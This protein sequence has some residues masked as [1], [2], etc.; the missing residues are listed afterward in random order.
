MQN[1]EVFHDGKEQEDEAE[2][3]VSYEEMRPSK[4]TDINPHILYGTKKEEAV[5]EN[6]LTFRPSK[7]RFVN[8]LGFQAGYL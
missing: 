3:P 5:F 1:M 6:S 2:A 8:Y 7:D 4:S